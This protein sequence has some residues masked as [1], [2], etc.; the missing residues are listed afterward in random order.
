MTMDDDR[1]LPSILI[2]GMDEGLRL[3]E[4]LSEAEA[5]ARRIAH[6]FALATERCEVLRQRYGD[7]A[8]F[9]KDVWGTLKGE[10]LKRPHPAADEVMPNEP[11]EMRDD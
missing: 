4:E 7:N 8:A 2:K 11:A 5:A 6:E 10:W 1:L 9:V 3:K